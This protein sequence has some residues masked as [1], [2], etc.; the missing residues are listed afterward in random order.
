[1]FDTDLFPDVLLFSFLSASVL[2]ALPAVFI[3]RYLRKV[4]EL[5]VCYAL[6][7]LAIMGDISD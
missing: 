1:M 4:G 5:V 3:E 6:C 7:M 2:F